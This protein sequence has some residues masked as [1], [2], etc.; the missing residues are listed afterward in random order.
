[1]GTLIDL[2]GQTFGRL[3]VLKRD[4]TVDKSK[5]AYW[6]CK[7]ECG[8]IR[9]V[10]SYS[11]KSGATQ[12]CGCL[13]KEINSKE[14][15]IH[16]MIGNKFGKLTVIKRYGTHIAKNGQKKPTWLCKCDCGNEKVATGQDLKTGH[17]K[18]CGCMSKKPK[19]SGLIDLTNKRFGKL[20]V[21]KRAEDYYYSCNGKQTSAPRWLCKCDCGNLIVC[22]GGNLRSGN[23][24]HCGCESPASKSELFISNFLTKNKIQYLREYT[25]NDLSNKANRPFR[26]DFGILDNQ[27]N[28]LMLVE[29]QGKQH[30]IDCEFGSYQREYSDKI[31][32]DYCILHNIPLYEIRYDE[33]LKESCEKLLKQIYILQNNEVCMQK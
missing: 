22:Q 28:L 27:S 30:Y 24:T 23:T 15:E 11:L 20:V 16:G 17:V 33:D 7:C 29:Y 12:S 4:M 9:S 26:F 21:I 32:K 14:K 13:N 8:N 31:K 2:T 25:F 10:K 19:G 5:G 18:S 6:I 3:T 1:M